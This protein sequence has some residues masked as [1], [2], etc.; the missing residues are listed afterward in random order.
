V[1]QVKLSP[2]RAADPVMGSITVELGGETIAST[3]HARRVLE[4]SHPP[5]YYPP[6]DL[7]RDAFADGVLRETSGA[8]WCEWKGQASY[9]DDIH[10]RRQTQ[11]WGIGPIP[12]SQRPPASRPRTRTNP[13][14]ARPK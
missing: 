1:G 14:T 3:T 12:R 2:I 9:H 4:I 8:S 7:P 5:T 11:H 13:P 6:R 10:R